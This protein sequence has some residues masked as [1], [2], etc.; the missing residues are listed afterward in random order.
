MQK[1]DTNFEGE[2]RPDYDRASLGKG[3]RGRHFAEYQG[4]TNVA[5]L[6]PDVRAA[7][8]TDEELNDALR[9]LIRVARR[10]AMPL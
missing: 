5:F 7:F 4:G 8:P 3:T 9:L 2:M 6:A 1:P 10:E